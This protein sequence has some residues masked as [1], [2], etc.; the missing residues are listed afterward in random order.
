MSLR[1]VLDAGPELDDQVDGTVPVSTAPD[2]LGSFWNAVFALD[3]LRGH[4]LGLCGLRLC[5]TRCFLLQHVVLR[6][7][8][9]A[10]AWSSQMPLLRILYRVIRGNLILARHI[11]F[12][13]FCK[14]HLRLLARKFAS[15][16]G[17]EENLKLAFPVRTVYRPRQKR[18]VVGFLDC[19]PAFIR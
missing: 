8:D 17:N 4:Q 19:D 10:A 3:V 15:F 9:Q 14:N 13:L 6:M 5:L 1:F 18:G 7:D 12:F 2:C 16:A 11:N